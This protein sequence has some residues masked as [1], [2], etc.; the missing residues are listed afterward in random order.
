MDPD[1]INTP[2]D[3]GTE[4][5]TP[6]TETAEDWNYFD[7]EEDTEEVQ[8]PEATDEGTEEPAETEEAETP[9]ALVA[10]PDGT[11]LPLEEVVKGYQRQADYTRKT[12]E[13]A[14]VRKALEADL[15]VISGITETFVDHLSKMVPPAPDPALAMRDPSAYTRAMALHTSAMQRVQEL[16][17]L[18]KKP[19]EISENL[20]KSDTEASI[21]QENLRLAERFPDVVRPEGRK[22][23]FEGAAKAA[24]EAGFSMDEMQA[25]TDHRY[26][27]MAHWANEGLKAAKARETAK[28]KVANVPPATPRKPGQPAQSNGNAEAMRKLSRSGS[29]RDAM[30]VDWD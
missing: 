23:F 30:R 21:T 11:Q 27:V 24:Q 14:Q 3:A 28:A 29:I 20:S 16:I 18:G 22:K 17:E 4:N 6:E 25:V 15:Q 12:Q 26:F 9:A 5:V 19:K 8:A 1:E 2:A 13:T 7:P 10:L